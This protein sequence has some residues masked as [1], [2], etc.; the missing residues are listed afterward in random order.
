MKY[1]DLCIYENYI[2]YRHYA[3]YTGSSFFSMK[4]R[5]D[6]YCVNEDGFC[7]N[8]DGPAIVYT[9]SNGGGHDY[10]I[11]GVRLSFDEYIS[12]PEY[13]QYRYLKKHP[14]LQGFV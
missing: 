7:H 1:Y 9:A 4:D 12:H 11:N 5:L 10:F 2:K 3:P 13:I 6:S 8:L 14:E